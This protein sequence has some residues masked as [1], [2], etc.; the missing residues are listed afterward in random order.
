[1]QVP[2]TCAKISHIPHFLKY[3][4]RNRKKRYWFLLKLQYSD[5]FNSEMYYFL[6]MYRQPRTATIENLPLLNI[7][8]A[9]QSNTSTLFWAYVNNE[10]W[11]HYEITCPWCK[12]VIIPLPKIVLQEVPIYSAAFGFWITIIR[13]PLS[14]A[15]I[16]SFFLER[17]LKK[18]SSSEGSTVEIRIDAFSVND[19]ISEACFF[20]WSS[21][22]EDCI[23]EP[24]I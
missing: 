9:E 4:I 21:D 1:M 19:E 6:N 5:K 13:N 3:S 17:T 8:Y 11:N 7:R 14:G 18:F 20:A 2:P 12:V 24:G 10:T 23:I 15:I 16:I 22:S